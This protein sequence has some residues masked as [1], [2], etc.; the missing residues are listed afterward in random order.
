[1]LSPIRRGANVVQ[2]LTDLAQEEGSPCERLG[3]QLIDRLPL[4]SAPDC[5]AAKKEEGGRE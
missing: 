5:L 1:M 4:A 3:R 2:S